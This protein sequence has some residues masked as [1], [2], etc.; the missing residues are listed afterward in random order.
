MISQI[1]EEDDVITISINDLKGNVS[2]FSLTKN[3]TEC[4]K[5]NIPN[6][7]FVQ[8]NFDIFKKIRQWAEDRNLQ[9]GDPK[10][11]IL[12]L[13]EESGELASG[14]AKN[15]DEVI[16]DSIGDIIVVL[17]VLSLQ[18]GISIEDCIALAYN[19][20]KDRKGKLINGVFV[21][22]SDL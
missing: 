15:N 6:E 19:E 11:Q 14:L 2:S 1:I 3:E 21:K 18:L 10:G 12:K 4:S 20:I 17:T 5:L 22:E 9:T 7:H 13:L 16:K 8:N